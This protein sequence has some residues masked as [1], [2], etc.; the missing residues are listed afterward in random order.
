MVFYKTE[1]SRYI[2]GFLH[3]GPICS[4]FWP[5]FVVL[6]GWPPIAYLI[7]VWVSRF[8]CGLDPVPSALAIM[9]CF[10]FQFGVFFKLE[11]EIIWTSWP[12]RTICKYLFANLAWRWAL[13]S[14]NFNVTWTTRKSRPYPILTHT[15]IRK[16]QEVYQWLGGGRCTGVPFFANQ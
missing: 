2:R 6:F 14:E 8:F 3:N 11:A 16:K 7:L 9:T 12:A 1:K 10:R 5:D 15:C 4:W 13:H